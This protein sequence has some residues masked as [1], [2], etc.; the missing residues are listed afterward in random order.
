MKHFNYILLGMCAVVVFLILLTVLE[1][2]LPDTTAF[3]LSLL[4]YICVVICAVLGI[5]MV[6]DGVRNAHAHSE[7]VSD[8]FYRGFNITMGIVAILIAAASVAVGL[9]L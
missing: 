3:A 6:A 2:L 8:G 1:V 9:L 7:S 4:R 5:A